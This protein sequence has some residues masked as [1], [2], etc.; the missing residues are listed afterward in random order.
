MAKLGLVFLTDNGEGVEDVGR[1][2]AGQAV[3]EEAKDTEPG[4]LMSSLILVPDKPRAIVTWI[5]SGRR[6]IVGSVG[7]VGNAA[8]EFPGNAA[9]NSP[10]VDFGV[11]V[12]VYRVDLAGG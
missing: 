11:C 3:E 6:H 2:F 7:E 8:D 4:P 12:G 10:L 9:A 1:V 5:P